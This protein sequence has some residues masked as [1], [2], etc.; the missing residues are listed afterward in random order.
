MKRMRYAFQFL[1]II[2][3]PC[4]HM[5]GDEKDFGKSSAWFPVVGLFQGLLLLALYLLSMMLF[6]VEVTAVL[7]VCLLTLSNGGFHVDGLSDTFDAIASR[8]GK[9]RMME[10]MK[11]SAA[12]PIGVI[13]VVLVL[14]VKYVLL[15][16]VLMSIHE[17]AVAVA[18]FPVAG[19]WAMVVTLSQ[20]KSA[21]AKGI[22][23]VF[24]DNTGYT[25]FFI[26][27]I[28]LIVIAVGVLGA[29][30][31]EAMDLSG[32][33]QLALP[34][35]G[36]FTGSVMFRKYFMRRLGGMTGDTLGAINELSEVLFLLLFLAVY[37]T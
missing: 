8:T 31:E 11:D 36:V 22:G 20:G 25:E 15:K 5:H 16:N 13:A 21:S 10:I 29:G 33:M 24:L 26:S 1:T 14:L 18:L 4:G 28:T 37:T 34:F 7:M 9:E 32:I 23:K 3:F 6:S 35:A 12:G 17:C 27:S 2:P 30:V 19:K